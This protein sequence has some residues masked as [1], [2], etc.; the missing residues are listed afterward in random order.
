MNRDISLRKEILKLA[1]TVPETRRYLLPILKT[2]APDYE[3]YVERKERAGEHPLEEP[4]WERR[5][6]GKPEEG[7]APKEPTDK[8]EQADEPK[9]KPKSKEEAPKGNLKSK[10]MNLLKRLKPHPAIA[11]AIQDSPDSVHKLLTDQA[12]RK[13]VFKDLAADLKKMP[14]KLLKSVTASAKHTAQEFKLGG[15]AFH[16]LLA[17][18]PKSLEKRDIKALAVVGTTVAMTAFAFSTGGLAATPHVLLKSIAKHI[19]ARMAGE[20]AA[21]AFLTYEGAEVGGKLL[22]AVIHTITA[23]DKTKK[24]EDHMVAVMTAYTIKEIQKGL[25]D[26]DIEKIIEQ[27]P[28]E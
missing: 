14:G 1:H 13:T 27:D 22:D 7:T 26:K 18:G 25:A 4:E 19:G 9:P 20:L 12:H 21:G 8:S 6:K 16:K 11:K 17:L 2:A 15:L 5:V 3:A 28:E 24:E 10:V 23:A